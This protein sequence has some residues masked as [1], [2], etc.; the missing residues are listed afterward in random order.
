MDIEKLFDYPRPDLGRESYILLDG[1]FQ[2]EYDSR[3]VGKKKNWFG[4]PDFTKK[5]IAPF[6]PQSESSGICDKNP[7]NIIWYAKRFEIK[8]NFLEDKVLL[9]F[10]AVDYYTEVYLNG[11]HIGSHTGGYIP[12]CFEIEKYLKQDK[13][14]LVVR[15]YDSLSPFMARGKQ[16]VIKKP[17]FVFY[18]PISGIWQ[19]VWLEKIGRIYLKNF[20]VITDIDKKLAEFSVNLKGEI[21]NFNLEVEITTPD[22]KVLK[23]NF[24]LKKGAEEE[25]F[26]FK[27]EFD[28]IHTWS[29]EDPNLYGLKFLIKKDKSTDLVKSYFGFRKIEVKGDKIYLNNNYLYQKLILNQ[30]YFKKGIYT[31]QNYE[32]FKKDVELI[33]EM[34]FNGLRMHQKIENKKF[35]FWCDYKGLLVW[36]EM[37]S[38]YFY[39]KKA[40]KNW[41]KQYKE[42]IERDFNHP[43][44]IVW[45]PFNESWGVMHVVILRGIRNFLKEIYEWTKKADPTRLVIDNSGF[46]HVRSD[47]IDIHHYLEDIDRCREFYKKISKGKGLEFSF[48][49]LI[50]SLSPGKSSH[51]TLCPGVK[52]N[53]EPIIISEYGG[54]GFYKTKD[55]DLLKQFSEYTKEIENC[56]KIQGYCYTQFTDVEQEANGLLTIERKTKIPLKRVKEAN[57]VRSCFLH[58][59]VQSAKRKITA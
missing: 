50:K 15:V 9:H 39:S 22:N 8:E 32:E 55:K 35:L 20:R 53:N 23:K 51:P 12:F 54:F 43:C 19:S 2:F 52:Y 46:D 47:I 17:I 5:I 1:E 58:N 49:N 28:K 42:L 33:K 14:L 45:I 13:N 37:P 26:K 29:P 36:D 27:L 59:E 21:G 41:F 3:N 38:F 57:G 48:I 6:P 34:G 56:P 25:E 30:G 18:T 40:R 10:G 7:P 11:N 31:P 4:D 24:Q 16:N 44:V